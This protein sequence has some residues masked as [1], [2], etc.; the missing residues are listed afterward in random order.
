VAKCQSANAGT[1]TVSFKIFNLSNMSIPFSTITARY[2]YTLEDPDM[3]LP[4]IEFDYLQS[5]AKTAIKTTATET[6]VE[7]GFTT[8]A[9][10]LQA[11][12]NISGTGEIQV[13]M[14]PPNYTPGQWDTNQMNDPS[15]KSCTGTTFDPRP[16]FIGYVGGRQSWPAP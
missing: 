5:L 1:I 11:F 16:G 13:R 12:D 14:H 7:F 10:N 8:A 3:T 6:Y 4:V 2:F 15:F 9:G